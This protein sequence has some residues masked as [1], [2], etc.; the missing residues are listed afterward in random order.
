MTRY[1]IEIT[2]SA[3]KD[4]LEIGLY[5]AKELL[6]P[7]IARK[8]VEKISKEI[9]TLEE[10]PLRYA[11]VRDER[12]SQLGIRKTFVDNYTIFYVTDDIK[13]SVTVIRILFS[14]RD[15]IQLL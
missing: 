5:I 10:M 2:E 6:E 8:L 12:L 9:F 13:K 11:L 7:D 14:R 4:L 15:W 1:K 3:E